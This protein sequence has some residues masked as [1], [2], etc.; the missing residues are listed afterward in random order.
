[1]EIADECS[2]CA[3]LEERRQEL[4]PAMRRLAVRV[5][6][7]APPAELETWLLDEFDAVRLPRTRLSRGWV[8]AVS[9]ALAASVIAGTLLVRERPAAD[10]AKAAAVQPETQQFVSIPFTAPLQPYERVSVVETD[11]PVSALIAAGF[12]VHGS[13]PGA[14][15]RADVMVSQDG[16]ARAIRPITF[17]ISDRR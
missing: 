17:S 11:V 6:A 4:A 8:A 9:G 7:L 16:R 15:V 3:A 12:E 10:A 13:D 14:R 2:R 5:A 1:L